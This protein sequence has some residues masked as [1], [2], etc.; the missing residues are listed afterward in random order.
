MKAR[1]TLFFILLL[2]F[3]PRLSA[4]PGHFLKELNREG[5][6]L[7]LVG[8]ISQDGRGLIWFAS[9]N[10]VYRYDGTNLKRYTLSKDDPEAVHNER[11]IQVEADGD[12]VWAIDE[13]GNLF[14]YD[15]GIDAFGHVNT[16]GVKINT[17]FGGDGK[18]YS[19]F[20][21]DDGRLASYID[22]VLEVI[23]RARDMS[24]NGVFTRSDGKVFY[25]MSGGLYTESRITVFADG[26]FCAAEHKGQSYFGSTLGR[27]YRYDDREVTTIYLGTFFH[28]ADLCVIPGTDELMA[29]TDDGT[30]YIHDTFRKTTHILH[31]GAGE[32]RSE[33]F[34]DAN[35]VVW[36]F[37]G[38]DILYWY[39]R[40]HRSL[41][42]FYDWESDAEWD[43]ENDIATVFPDRQ[44]NLW[45][46]SSLTG[47]REVVFTSE[48]FNFRPA[49][50]GA[51]ISSA[52]SVRASMQDREGNFWMC[53]RDRRVHVFNRQFRLIGHLMADGSV[54]REGS[55]PIGNVYAITQTHDRSVWLACKGEG[56]FEL[57]PSGNR[58][59][60]GYSIRHYTKDD[61]DFYAIPSDQ[62][63]SLHEDEG[64]R[65]WIASFDEGLSYV[66]L[67]GTERS[68]ISRSNRLPFPTSDRNRLRY[69]TS[70]PDGSIITSGRLGIFVLSSPHS[71]PEDMHFWNISGFENEYYSTDDI[72]YLSCIDSTV[73]A[74][75]FGSG[76]FRVNPSDGSKLERITMEDGLL[77][78]IL[79]SSVYDEKG[80]LWIATAGG[81]NKYN[82]ESGSLVSYPYS[83]MGEATIFNEGSPMLASDGLIYFNTNRGL[84][85]FNP[86]EISGSRYSPRIIILSCKDNG[87]DLTRDAAAGRRIVIRDDD[88][89]ALEFAAADMKDASN[90]TFHYTIEGLDEGWS[91]I[92]GNELSFS[93]L[94]NGN[95]ILRIR[96]TNSDGILTDNTVSIPISVRWSGLRD[97]LLSLA[98]ILVLT[99]AIALAVRVKRIR[100]RKKQES[101]KPGR[102]ETYLSGLNEADREFG[103]KLLDYIDGNLED[104]DLDIPAV[105]DY[106]NMS[107]S[108]L[109]KRTKAIFGKTPV[110]LIH[111]ARIEKACELLDSGRYLIAQIADMTGYNDQQY[112]SKAFKKALGMTP[113][114]YR[115]KDK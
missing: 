42:K 15:P 49:S 94:K 11:V 14:R 3:Q 44:G 81:L 2:L 103:E 80:N 43:A 113:S 85:Y 34:S 111:E 89:L 61:D 47:I 56:L 108:V 83:R 114:E 95:Y 112:F 27:I 18:G 77:S 50:E 29:V 58:V 45:I 82:I 99:A 100:D 40:E 7:R 60:D 90:I 86:E 28:V 96:S 21:T 98:G 69:V 16:S 26:A 52:N 102:K 9:L 32:G 54:S 78:N 48:Q 97:L 41:V 87:R 93:E 19:Y 33:L 106:M 38:Q 62:L 72:Q 17:A 46:S 70:G 53:T 8:D 13:N 63:Y 73:F 67:D 76:L 88:R 24:A 36:V 20:S 59:H 71:E 31:T 105:S 75:S 92:R 23:P 51:D 25:L 91:R 64:R 65:L 110:D 104:R 79:L 101:G 107:R 39:D 12:C 10:G 5:Y 68:F 74:C 115:K 66:D 37:S 6:D 22:G 35:G 55:D 57:T 4:V 1:Y 30:V 84:L 109:Y